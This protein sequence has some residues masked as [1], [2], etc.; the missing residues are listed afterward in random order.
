MNH[1]SL[2]RAMWPK[3][4][5]FADR[6]AQAVRRV[7]RRVNAWPFE[8]R[9]RAARRGPARVAAGLGIPATGRDLTT[10]MRVGTSRRTSAHPPS[11]RRV[12][13]PHPRSSPSPANQDRAVQS[14]HAA[15]VVIKPNHLL[16]GPDSSSCPMSAPCLLCQFCGKQAQPHRGESW[17]SAGC[18]CSAEDPA[19]Y[20]GA[21][22]SSSPT[23]CCS[24]SARCRGSAR[25]QLRCGDA[26]ADDRDQL[27]RYGS[28]GRVKVSRGAVARRPGGALRRSVTKWDG[29]RPIIRVGSTRSFE[30]CPG[31][32]LRR[33]RWWVVTRTSGRPAPCWREPVKA[34]GASF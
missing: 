23:S 13:P 31:W 14:P 26:R 25:L 1:E 29:G 20:R 16:R 33:L 32:S 21:A 28:G 5:D 2:D 30:G 34:R 22:G 7:S 17:H 18:G 6:G 8:P 3:R 4:G 15:V 9:T 19:A 27:R 12:P 10:W 24:R 11:L